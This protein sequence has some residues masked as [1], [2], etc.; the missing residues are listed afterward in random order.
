MNNFKFVKRH[1]M[2]MMETDMSVV[3]PRC[4]FRK[5]YFKIRAP[6]LQEDVSDYS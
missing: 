5:S 3:D 6:A 4:L 1:L 2:M